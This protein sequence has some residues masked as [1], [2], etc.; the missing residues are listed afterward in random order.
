MKKRLLISS[1]LMSAVLACAL[2]TGT[3]AWYS[4]SA[5]GATVQATGAD[6]KVSVADPNVTTSSMGYSIVT[7]LEEVDTVG[8]TLVLS[9]YGKL[10][11]TGEDRWYSAYTDAAGQDKEYVLNQ[12]Q[13]N[14]TYY[15]LYSVKITGTLDQN[16]DRNEF[17]AIVEGTYSITFASEAGTYEEGAYVANYAASMFTLPNKNSIVPGQTPSNTLEYDVKE[18]ATTDDDEKIIGYLVVY[19]DGENIDPAKDL[20]VK[21]YVTGSADI[22]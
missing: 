14:E 13:K 12:N 1:V 6:G 19:L 15:R 5:G 10:N 8:K 9:H 3:Y 2:G 4:A 22:N 20:E 7:T 21:A 11:G 17:E 16:A 18:L